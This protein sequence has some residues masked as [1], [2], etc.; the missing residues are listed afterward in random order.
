MNF[1]TSISPCNHHPGQDIKHFQNPESPPES[2]C[3]VKDRSSLGLAVPQRR[4]PVRFC[5]A[6]AP[7]AGLCW[8][9][10]A[11][12]TALGG[13]GH[14]QAG[15]DQSTSWFSAVVYSPGSHLATVSLGSF[16]P[17]VCPIHLQMACIIFPQGG[18]WGY[19][20]GRGPCSHVPHTLPSPYPTRDT[21]LAAFAIDSF[22]LFFNFMWV[23]SYSIVYTILCLASC[24]D[25]PHFI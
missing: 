5:A 8:G 17:E 16:L 18:R 21:I 23:E 1:H 2:L 13:C 3:C 4:P 22:C 20:S 10:K 15:G 24:K 12:R 11:K 7:R 19:S 25:L 9:Q 6:Q 14:A